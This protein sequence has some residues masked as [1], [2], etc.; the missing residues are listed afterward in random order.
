M[1]PSSAQPVSTHIR[2]VTQLKCIFSN[3]CSM[4][5]VQEEL[6][7]IVQQANHTLVAITEMW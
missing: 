4:S 1:Q 5:N 7:A 6:E 3:T 2:T